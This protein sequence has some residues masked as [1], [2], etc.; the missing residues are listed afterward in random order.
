MKKKMNKRD[1]GILLVL[2]DI[3]I[4]V[5]VYVYLSRLEPVDNSS[6]MNILYFGRSKLFI[7]GLFLILLD[8]LENK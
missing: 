5:C 4:C 7:I 1:L 2:L 8:K 3:C 6:F